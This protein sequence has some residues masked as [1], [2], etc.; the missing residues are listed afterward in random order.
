MDELDKIKRYLVAPEELKKAKEFLKGKTILALEDNQVR[1]DWFL[2][3][4]AFYPKI[5]TPKEAFEK[6]DKVTAKEVQSLAKE[7]FKK[8]KM[9]LAIIGPYKSDKTFRKL[10]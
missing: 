8:E 2:D 5:T 6:I 4:A 1:L 3:R 10:I 9:S 7:L